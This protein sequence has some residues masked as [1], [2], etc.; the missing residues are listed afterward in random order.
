MIIKQLVYIY[1]YSL[2]LYIWVCTSIKYPYRIFFKY[3]FFMQPNKKGY[4]IKVFPQAINLDSDLT[5]TMLDSKILVKIKK[6][7][8]IWGFLL[9]SLTLT[10]PKTIFAIWCIKGHCNINY[11][12][13]TSLRSFAM[14]KMVIINCN[15]YYYKG[16]P[17]IKLNIP[18][19]NGPYNKYRV[20]FFMNQTTS[21][22]R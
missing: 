10:T 15:N 17:H 6:G 5:L 4:N 18:I 20:T 1:I 2:L 12:N 16:P 9:H 3:F 13:S 14:S 11:Y 21:I 7:I 19:S 22:C 8:W